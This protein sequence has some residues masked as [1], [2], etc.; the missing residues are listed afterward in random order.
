MTEEHR[1]FAD[2][3]ARFFRVELTPNIDAWRAQ[4][5]V[6][7]DFWRKAG[8]AGLLGPSVPQQ[9]GGAG[10]D[11]TFDA[12]VGIEQTRAGDPNWGWS[13]HNIALHYVLAYGTEQQKERWLPGMASGELVVAIA[14]TEPDAG[15]DLQAIRTNAVAVGDNYILNGSK[16]FISN[17]QTADLIIVV[18]KT[19][20]SLRAKGISLL[21]VEAATAHGFK[22][23]RNLRKLGLDGSDT[24]E[25]FFQD[26]A[27]PRS[28][29]L[30]LVEGQG[31]AQLMRQL[32]WERLILAL[33]CVPMMESIIDDALRHVQ[34][35]KTFGKRLMDYQNTRFTLAECKTKLDVTRA[36]IDQCMGELAAGTL[37]AEVASTAKW[38]ATQCLNEVV[39]ECLQL[40]GGAGLMLENPVAHWYR[41]ARFLKIVGGANEIMKEMIARSM[42]TN[43]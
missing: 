4:G 25:L 29:L 12:I 9:Y 32:P 10:G 7:R 2:S 3:A 11:V 20:L 43:A 38:W 8:A 34:A 39:D 1:R 41:D 31:F 24:S 16:I 14:M 26:V 28:N 30:G 15:S 17:G 35:R 40:Y 42:E 19:D 18:C 13:A 33:V 27:V 22:R 23:G 6:D 21:V 5:V 37:K 36:F